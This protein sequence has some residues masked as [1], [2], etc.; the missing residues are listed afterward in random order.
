MLVIYSIIS[1]LTYPFLIIFSLFR[2][3]FKKEDLKSVLQK[4]FVMGDK[5]FSKPIW[6]HG[7]SIGE[8]K[9]IFPI[10]KEILKSNPS[11]TIII[12]STTLASKKIIEDE[13]KDEKSVQHLFFPYD[14]IF[15][16]KKS[17]NK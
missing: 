8:V 10:V 5:K 17:L 15:L 13:Y 4:I 9:S 1:I 7:A 16:A 14:V 3:L 12:S 2:F 6:F 11:I